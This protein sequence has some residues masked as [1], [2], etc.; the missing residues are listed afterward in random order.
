MSAASV[1]VRYA[2]PEKSAR[3][4]F[5]FFEKFAT[6]MGKSLSRWGWAG[7]SSFRHSFVVKTC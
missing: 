7:E 5:H 1:A 2:E 6:D 4:F 3:A